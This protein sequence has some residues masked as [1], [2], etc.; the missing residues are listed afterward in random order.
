VAGAGTCEGDVMIHRAL[1]TTEKL[2]LGPGP[3]PVSDRVRQAM[4]AP[5]R[6][7]L[8]PEF[9]LLLDDVRAGLGRLFKAPER[10]FTFALS[11]TGTTGMDAAAVNLM[12]RGMTV[13]C[14]VNG[15]FGERLATVLSLQGAF[16]ERLEGEWGRAIEPAKVEQVMSD[17]RFDALAIVHG[18]T[19]TGVLNP[20][21]DIA[22]IARK[23]DVFFIVDTVTSLGAA[24]VDVAAWGADVCY[25][26][27]QKGIGAPSGLAPITFSARAMQQRV[28]RPDFALDVQKLQDFWVRRAYHH[29]I[30]APLIY[31]LHAALAEVD[32]EGLEARWKRH[33]SVH[34]AFVTG[35]KGLNLELLPPAGERLVSLNAVAV[36]KGVDA[37]AVKER[38]LA[39]HDIEIGAG[40]GPLAG[41]IWRVGLMGS[42]ATTDNVERVLSA[43]A[44]ALGHARSK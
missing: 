5:I 16:V 33:Q 9:V 3:S 35:L 42:G 28:T 15:Y 13:L 7:H 25:S 19:S 38:L 43:F 31:A 39:K 23:H 22:A 29:T 30:S 27:S 11:G 34:E 26:C 36:P 4:T 2:L 32:D 44:E 40:L 12:E 41:R 14:V 17:G 21:G 10:H 18:E 20:V 37:G 24:P 6:S 8:D 1:P